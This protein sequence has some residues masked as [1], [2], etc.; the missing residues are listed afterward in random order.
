MEDN[1]FYIWGYQPHYWVSAKSGAEGICCLLDSRL[2]PKVFLVGISMNPVESGIPPVVLEPEDE[3]GYYTKDF[4]MVKELAKQLEIVDEESKIF[5]SHPLAQERHVKYLKQKAL[6]SAIQKTVDSD[7]LGKNIISFCSYPVEV[8]GFMVSVVL[9]LNKKVYESHYKLSKTTVYERYPIATSLIDAT[10]NKYLTACSTA[11]NQFEPGN[12]IGIFEK[13]YDE[14]VRSAGKSLMVTPAWAGNAISGINGLFEACNLI[15]SQKYEGEEALGGLIIAREDHPNVHMQL[16]LKNPVYI[17]NH[18]AVR[19]LLELARGEHFLVTDSNLIYGIGEVKGT[20]NS[21]DED[22]FIVNFRGHYFWSLSHAGNILMNV[23]YRQPSLPQSPINKGKFSD[24]IKR[25]FNV[26]SFNDANKL[27]SLAEEAT[28]QKNGAMLII[29]SGA[30]QEANRLCQQGT[31]INP[32]ELNPELLKVCTNIDGGVLVDPNGICWAI[33]VIL[34]GVAT[35]KGEPSRGSR[36]NSAVRYIENTEYPSLILVVSEDG[37]L[38]FIPDLRPQIKKQHI[39][40]H[41]S[42]LKKMAE[43][44]LVDGKPFYYVMDW[45]KDHEFY[46]NK[47]ICDEINNYRNIIDPKVDR[48]LK[49]S[50]RDLKPNSEMNDSYF[51]D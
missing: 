33:G 24:D 18:R 35:P 9:E 1:K 32:V 37:M 38:N 16:S 5:H 43:Q 23:K 48:D 8:N 10:I 19:K 39:F 51:I 42:Q 44:E 25:I 47:E 12:S 4:I 3:C 34:D 21:C 29:S 11:L 49:I 6:R 14:I 41:I 30:S 22:L 31:P 13:E 27:C 28:Y 2:K 46:L 20:Y 40:E 26:S 45:L 50:Y 17:Q 15:S 36:Y 7:S